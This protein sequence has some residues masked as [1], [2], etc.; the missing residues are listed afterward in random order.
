MSTP[1]LTWTGGRLDGTPWQG[2]RFL[3]IEFDEGGPFPAIVTAHLNRPVGSLTAAQVVIGGGRRTPPPA[4]EIT[5]AGS[6]IEV[7]F[8]GYGD[9]SPYTVAIDSGGGVPLHPFFA[10]AEF[11][12][13]IDCAFGD[14]RD[15]VQEATRPATQPPAVDLLTKDFNGFVG[16]L[17]D[18][19]KIK[20]PAMVDL[21]PASLER[22]LLDLLAWMGDMLSYQQDRVAGEAFLE[23]ARQRFS[24]RQ[25]ALLLGTAVD[26]GAAPT[27]LVGVDVES[28]GFM[29]AGLQIRTRT[30]PDEAPVVFTVA[31]RAAVVPEHATS[32][33][34]VAAFPGAADAVI[35]SGATEVLLWGHGDALQS[36]DQVA[37]VQGTFAQ[38]VTLVE[39][40]QRLEEAGWVA[41][42]ADAFDPVTDP[43]AAVTRLRW[44]EPL[45]QELRPWGGTPLAIHGNLVPVR[46]GAPR[47]AIVDPYA[48][49]RRDVI[50]R[51]TPRTSIVVRDD[52][53]YR[54]RALRVPEWPVVHDAASPETPSVPAVDVTI[55]GER[56]TRVEH[57]HASRSYDLHF[58]AEADEEGAVWLRFGDGVL[59]REVPLTDA[60]QPAVDIVLEYRVGDPVAGNV[61]LGTLVDVVRPATGTDEQVALD[62]LGAVAVTNVLPASGGRAPHTLPRT[63]EDLRSSLRN[64][65]LQRAVALQDYASVAMEVEGVARATVRLLGG[66]FNTVLILVDPAGSEDL[67]EALRARVHAHLDSRRMAGR[68]HVVEAADYVPLE[69]ELVICAQPGVE[70]SLVRDRVLAELRPGTPERP[71]WFHPDRL[72]FGDAVRLGDVLAF[73]Q[74]IAGVRSVK[75]TRFRPLGDR[76]AVEVRDVIALGSTNVARL[77]A[78]PDFPE[79]GTLLVRAIGLDGDASA[80]QIDG[81]LIA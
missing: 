70:R 68:E 73:V 49:S 79:N 54:L 28:A 20:N 46:F 66:L 37:L 15:P 11:H 6:T 44:A 76:T 8:R 2:I 59:G 50:V 38:V 19:V 43:P 35:S 63:R 1:P 36:G 7:R 45:L 67:D 27:T 80:L 9:H 31:E 13:T 30:S 48:Q 61:G 5:L 57:F 77:D 78:D 23:T 34:R 4:H 26:D 47:R 53:A 33:L 71:G 64:G 41:D 24:M 75:A 25:H 22:M 10:S 3:S 39:S 51:L 29:P 12:F 18:W 69:V 74:S 21:S 17:S 72:S 62:A 14:C 32:A 55:S 81:A 52:D 60:V 42:P 58:T 16:L 40:P 56:W 65:P